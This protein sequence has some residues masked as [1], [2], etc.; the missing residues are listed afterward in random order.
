M[1]CSH[2][3][4]APRKSDKAQ[5]RRAFTLIELLVVIAIIAIIAAILFPVFSRARENAR[6]A[7]CQSNLKQIGLGMA[8]Y[9]QDYDEKYLID[10]DSAGPSGAGQTFVKTLDPYI[11]ST[12]VFI[13][14][15]VPKQAINGPQPTDDLTIKDGTWLAFGDSGAYGLNANFAARSPSKAMSEIVTPA[16][17]PMAFDCSWYEAVAAIDPAGSVKDATRHFTGI[18]ICFAD[19]HVKWFGSTRIPDFFYF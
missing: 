6:R 15:S 4:G 9:T 10:Q 7:S 2:N 19:G 3:R 18:N 14:P 16:E 12:Q 1:F 5:P 17:A 11:K 13:C 8:Q